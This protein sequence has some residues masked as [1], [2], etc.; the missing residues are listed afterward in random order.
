MEIKKIVRLS[1]QPTANKISVEQKWG[2]KGRYSICI[3]NKTK[4]NKTKS[5]EVIY[6]AISLESHRELSSP[7]KNKELI[8]YV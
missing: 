6:T 7:F 4:L 8:S 5:I 3:T 2:N 1:V